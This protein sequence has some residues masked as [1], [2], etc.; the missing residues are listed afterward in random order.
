MALTLYG[1]LYERFEKCRSPHS[2]GQW[3]LRRGGRWSG[4]HGVVV[5]ILVDNGS[6]TVCLFLT[7]SNFCRSP[8]SRGQWLLQKIIH[9]IL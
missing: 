6:Y 2:R 9:F 4:L 3:L 7:L 1:K 8:H 5:L